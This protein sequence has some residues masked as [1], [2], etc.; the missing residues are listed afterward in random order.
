MLIIPLVLCVMC[1]RVNIS[2]DICLSPFVCV[3][4]L[5]LHLH[6]NICLYVGALCKC[7]G[8]VYK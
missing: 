7:V 8:H 5:C 6:N 3:W 1:V 2:V 4:V